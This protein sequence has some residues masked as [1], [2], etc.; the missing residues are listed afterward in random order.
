MH[1]SAYFYIT[2]THSSTL[3]FI[4]LA[5]YS[6]NSKI[7]I[8]IYEL[9]MM[10]LWLYNVY[11]CMVIFWRLNVL[12]NNI[13][14]FYCVCSSMLVIAIVVLLKWLQFLHTIFIAI[15]ACLAGKGYFLLGIWNCMCQYSYYVYSNSLL[16]RKCVFRRCCS[17]G[18]M[19]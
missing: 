12:W 16:N 3:L 6:F 4:L 17:E 9:A 8:Y 19:Y 13:H 11:I 1:I 18:K 10:F 14:L 15:G 7:H 2:S 5:V